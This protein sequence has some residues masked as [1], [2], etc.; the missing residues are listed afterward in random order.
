M[1][2]SIILY[3]SLSLQIQDLRSE[4]ESLRREV[5]STTVA[6]ETA[7]DAVATLRSRSETLS[8]TLFSELEFCCQG[9][10]PHQLVAMECVRTQLAG[11]VVHLQAGGFPATLRMTSY[12][13]HKES[14]QASLDLSICKMLS[15]AKILTYIP[16]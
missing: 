5:K 15:F 6:V 11:D 9:R 16:D 14:G 3:Q 12:S 8:H 4:N 1:F 10:E 2:A 7:N 13:N